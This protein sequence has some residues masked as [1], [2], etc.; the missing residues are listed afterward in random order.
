MYIITRTNFASSSAAT[1]AYKIFD[2]TRTVN[3]DQNWKH[4]I[5][6]RQTDNVSYRADVQ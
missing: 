4:I 6:N 5:I 3:E 2:D 1:S